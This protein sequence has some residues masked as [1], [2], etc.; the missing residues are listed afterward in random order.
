MLTLFVFSTLMML[1]VVLATEHAVSP[2]ESVIH[3]LT[4]SARSVAAGFI[5]FAGVS[6]VSVF[7]VS[8]VIWL[9]RSL[10]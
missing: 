8:G 3:S 4:R 1:V 7:I 5:I 2:R 6:F 9:L 10:L